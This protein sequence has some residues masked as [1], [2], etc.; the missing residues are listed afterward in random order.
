MSKRVLIISIISIIIFILIVVG[1]LFGVYI[2]IRNNIVAKSVRTEEAWA[3]VQNVYQ[4]RLD[5]SAKFGR[6]CKSVS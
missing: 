5:L 2:N 3:Q 1:I 6:I 4:R